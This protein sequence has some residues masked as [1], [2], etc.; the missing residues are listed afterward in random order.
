MPDSA[1]NLVDHP[2]ALRRVGDCRRRRGTVLDLSGLGL[3]GLPEKTSQLAKLTEL[4]LSH[5]QLA[6]LPPE[7]AGFENLER[8][9]LSHN[10]L[11]G[12]PPE[13]GRFT[14]L[15]WLDLSHNP[16]AAVPPELGGLARLT[17][18]YLTHCPLATLPPELGRL[19]GLTRLYLSNNQL[20]SLPPELGGLVNL[21]RLD[22]AGNPLGTL[23]PELGRLAKLTVLGLSN[24]RLT[25]VP[26]EFGGLNKLTVLDLTDN[27]LGS[28][29]EE[30]GGLERLTELDLINTQL[31]T[32]PEWL[33]TLEHLERLL[34]HDNPLLQLAPSVLGPDPRP[35]PGASP[36]PAKAILDFYYSREAATTRPLNEVRLVLLGPAGVGKTS[37][38]RALRDKPFREY[39]ERTRG[40]AIT[41]TALADGANAP[42]AVRIW[43]C[44]GAPA[45]RLVHPLFFSSRAVYLVVL[46]GLDDQAQADAEHWLQFIETHAAGADGK[47]PTVIVAL[48]QWNVPGCRAEVDRNALRER[49]PGLAGFVEMDCKAKKGLPILKAALARELDRMPWVHE[50]FLE[51][52][53]AVRGALVTGAVTRPYLTDAEFR[54]VCAAHGVPDAGQQDYLSDLLHHLGVAVD[55][56]RDP[57]LTALG[58]LDP[59]WLIQSLYPLV[60][61]AA[62]HAGWLATDDIA[63]ALPAEPDA[64]NRAL[65]MRVLVGIGLAHTEPGEADGPWLLPNFQPAA[66]ALDLAGEPGAIRLRA[67]YQSP[68]EF[69]IQRIILRRGRF[70][71]EVDGRKSHWRGGV[72]LV[73]K[74]ARAVIEIATDPHQITVTV[75]GPRGPRNHLAGLC[76]VEL[77]E[78]HA[79]LPEPAPVVEVIDRRRRRGR[80]GREAAAGA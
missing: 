41:D 29:P 11:A 34:L 35:S 40:L 14:A 60:S 23:P 68:P 73:R 67:I 58:V 69:I 53:D 8:L 64:A 44:A 42:V 48:N 26:P 38:A 27:P 63:A 76:E 19:A 74:E 31:H 20:R 77:E 43:D 24:T 36:V 70:I 33:G 6:S 52:W 79:G 80:G 49:F 51:Q 13:L 65:L 12:L 30:L 62:D 50:P 46:T 78:L 10:R 18:L 17:R 22:L 39:E 3:T 5:N 21:T 45:A 56:R 72:V 25:A 71:E 7:L 4:N 55:C 59:A 16:L 54:E 32:L 9:D 37:I 61:A 1:A 66:P 15:T 2:E 28:L 47:P 57:R 75:S